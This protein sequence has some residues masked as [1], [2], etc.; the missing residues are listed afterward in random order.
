MVGIPQHTLARWLDGISKSISDENYEKLFPLIKPYFKGDRLPWELEANRSNQQDL[1]ESKKMKQKIGNVLKFM[2]AKLSITQME[3]AKAIGVSQGTYAQ[4]ENGDYL[5][6]FPQL[7]KLASFFQCK[8][9]DI[10]DRL[11]VLKDTEIHMITDP[12]FSRRLR[13]YLVKINDEFATALI[14]RPDCPG[15]FDEVELKRIG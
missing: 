13:G 1:R 4:W 3:V 9:H 14:E 10:D 5:P 15:V 7:M 11:C 6:K 12:N 8:P 2:R